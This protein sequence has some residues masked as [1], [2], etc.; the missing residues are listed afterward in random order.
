MSN[1]P[2]VM[3]SKS[4]GAI[5]KVLPEFMQIYLEAGWVREMEGKREVHGGVGMNI[6]DEVVEVAAEALVS[7]TLGDRG[8]IKWEEFFEAARKAL[9][10]AAPK[11]LA[12]AWDDGYTTGNAHNG[13]RDANP[14]RKPCKGCPDCQGI[15]HPRPCTGTA[16]TGDRQCI[17]DAGH[18]GLCK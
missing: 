18:G 2:V 7:S 10:S 17:L 5:T 9:N 1:E 3:R 16:W 6:P 8:G 12:A 4:T 11:L 14:Y 15:P 13:R